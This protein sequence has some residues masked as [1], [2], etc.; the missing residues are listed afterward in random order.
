MLKVDLGRL[1]RE[2]RVELEAGLEPDV[3][4]WPRAGTRFVQPLEVRLEAQQAGSDVV[5]R[6]LFDVEVEMACRRCL[7]QVRV[8]VEEPFTLL[9]REGA[10]AGE[11]E[12]VYPLPADR[13]LD[14][15]EPLREHVLLAVPE[16]TLCDEACRG[17]CP[18]CGLNRNE[19]TCECTVSDKDPRWATLRRLQSE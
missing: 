19:G 18:V 16:L 4:E 14:L 15:L 5:V 13:D 9:F 6:G 2:R 1:H 3:L 17:L 7:R 11:S 10:E 8:R 12:D